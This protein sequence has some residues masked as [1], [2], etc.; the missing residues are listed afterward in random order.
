[1]EADY[2]TSRTIG[3]D[4]TVQLSASNERLSRGLVRLVVIISECV[5][6]KFSCK[7]QD[8]E[9]K[10]KCYLVAYSV[11]WLIKW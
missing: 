5:V 1:M 8:K 2:V 6:L 3:F 4:L 11:S 9:V 10:S 7:L